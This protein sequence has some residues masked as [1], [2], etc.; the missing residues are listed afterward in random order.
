MAIDPEDQKILD[1]LEAEEWQYIENVT[2][3]M[4][5]YRSYA[6][7]QLGKSVKIVLSNEDCDRLTSL[8]R[9]SGKST[10][11]LTQEILFKF[12]NG[13]LVKKIS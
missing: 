6:A 12:L 9:N 10:E 2:E 7:N 1:S 5:R 11:N 4:T 13:E 8:A 3:E